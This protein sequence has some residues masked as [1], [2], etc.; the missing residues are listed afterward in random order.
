MLLSAS[1]SH[2]I[3]MP[4]LVAEPV[5]SEI[6]PLETVPLLVEVDPPVDTGL[7]LPVPD[8]PPKEPVADG[9]SPVAEPYV[10]KA[11]CLCSCGLRW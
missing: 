10:G 3:P 1:D 4:Y 2:P 9:L 11:V 8:A 6:L 5:E 7:L